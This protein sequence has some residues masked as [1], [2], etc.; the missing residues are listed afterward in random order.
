MESLVWVPGTTST[1]GISSGGL[2]GCPTITR[3]PAPRP[4]AMRV[5]PI[6]EL[7]VANTA[8]SGADSRNWPNSSRLTARRSGPF[9]WTRSASA[10]TSASV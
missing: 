10:T 3:S 5:A 7:D 6:E 4:S 8:C 2:N 9:S 1:S